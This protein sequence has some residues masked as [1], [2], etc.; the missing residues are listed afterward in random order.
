MSAKYRV[1]RGLVV[2]SVVGQSRVSR[3]SSPVRFRLLVFI[4]MTSLCSQVGLSLSDLFSAFSNMIGMRVLNEPVIQQV[5][6]RLHDEQLAA[7]HGPMEN[8]AL[9]A[10]CM[11]SRAYA[12]WQRASESTMLL[13]ITAWTTWAP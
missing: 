5:R 3:E 1:S 6:R 4:S 12:V 8:L 2:G 10:S 9:L 13:T 11:C 7:M